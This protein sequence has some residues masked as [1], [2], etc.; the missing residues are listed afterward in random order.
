MIICVDFDNV[1]NDLTEKA[2]ALYNTR[3]GKNIQLS[4][5]TTYNFS[6]CLPK[7]DADGIV[8]LFADK[9]LWDSLKPLAGS[10]DVLRKLVRKGHRIYVATATDS[11]NFD[12]KCKWFERYFPFIPSNNVI[13]IMDKSLLQ[14]DVMIDDHLSN[15]TD[16]YCERICLDYPWNQSISKD[17]AYGIKRVNSWNNII[18]T[19]DNIEKEIKEWEKQ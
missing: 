2:I 14:V 1:L 16:N 11:I 4:D 18:N 17:F 13:R 7:E 15:L 8:A 10:R 9:E 19:I 3:N 6:D 5:I 12:W